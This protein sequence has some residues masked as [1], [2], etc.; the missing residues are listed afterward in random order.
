[1]HAEEMLKKAFD[2]KANGLSISETMEI[3]PL[4][5]EKAYLPIDVTPSDMVT[6]VRPL[7]D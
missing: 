6:E 5:S 1:M 2:P 7:Q 4:Q 3:I